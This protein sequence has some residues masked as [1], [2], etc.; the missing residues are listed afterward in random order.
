MNVSAMDDNPN[1]AR[2]NTN[3]TVGVND[4]EFDSNFAFLIISLLVGSV[5]Y[6]YITFY[7]SRLFGMIVTSIVNRFVGQNAYFKVG[8][9]CWCFVWVC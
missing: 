3:T 2:W 7:N 4:L 8:E 5:W 6:I 9:S 1:A